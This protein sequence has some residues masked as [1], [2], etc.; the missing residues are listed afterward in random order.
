MEHF[1]T[2]LK[3][4]GYLFIGHSETLHGLSDQFTVLGNTVYQK[5]SGR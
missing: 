3:D 4:D 5:R 2:H 1:A